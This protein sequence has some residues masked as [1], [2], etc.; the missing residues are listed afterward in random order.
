MN[1]ADFDNIL[2]KLD[3]RVDQF[4]KNM[5]IPAENSEISSKFMHINF[6]SKY[7]I[8]I[9]PPI[10]T[11]ILLLLWKPNFITKETSTSGTVSADRKISFK[12]LIVATILINIVIVFVYY[13]KSMKKF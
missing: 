12:K 6:K 5:N 1:D 2:K 4:A 3:D 11:I 10:I 8:Y 7:M 9:A 13:I